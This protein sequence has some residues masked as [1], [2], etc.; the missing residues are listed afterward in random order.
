MSRRKL[1]PVM[2]TR[3]LSHQRSLRTEWIFRTSLRQDAAETP[4]AENP[5]A[6][7]TEAPAEDPDVVEEPAEDIASP[8]EVPA[9]DEN[10]ETSLIEVL[11]DDT[12]LR[13]SPSIEQR[14]WQL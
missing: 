10:G 7:P 2:R 5:D 3:C 11:G 9:A 13:V 1:F 12:N 4:A 6:E 14:F 8:E